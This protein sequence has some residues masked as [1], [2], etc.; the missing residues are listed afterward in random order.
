MTRLVQE[1]DEEKQLFLKSRA[2]SFN[3]TKKFQYG[4]N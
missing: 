4:P 1:A 3:K 2:H